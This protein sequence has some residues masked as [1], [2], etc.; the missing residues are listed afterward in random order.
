MLPLTAWL[1]AANLAQLVLGVAQSVILGRWLGV[2]VYGELGYLLSMV[3]VADAVAQAGLPNI[4]IREV[5]AR[6][7]GD[8][9]VFGTAM[10]IRLALALAAA[11]AVWPVAGPWASALVLGY[12]GSLG[13]SALRAKLLRGP[14][15]AASLLPILLSTAALALLAARMA[16]SAPLALAV[17][18]VAGLLAGAGQFAIAK[19]HLLSGL[20]WSLWQGRRLLEESWPLWLGTLVVAWM[21]R[22]DVFL[23]KA[24]P[25]PVAS[26]D[27]IGWYQAAFKPIESGHNLLGALV[28]TAFPLF[29]ARAHRPAAL[30]SA[31]D[32][33]LR[34]ARLFGGAAMLAALAGGPWAIRLLYGE[35]YAQSGPAIRLLAPAL[36]LVLTNA[37]LASLLTA[38]GRQRELLW[39]TVAMVAFKLAGNLAVIPVWSFTGSAAMTTLTEAFGFGLL[40][41]RVRVKLDTSPRL[42]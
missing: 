16:P 40:W 27:A 28:L 22:I 12:A 2:A 42:T 32:A 36:V 11:A 23:L 41:W 31:L 29:S 24:L 19:V 26:A 13:V 3:M 39:I 20:G 4:V 34:H 18:A 6:P 37:L 30:R 38:A 7:R 9:L 17:L 5:A 10:A 15:I 8:G 33:N 35:A 14:Q 1:A 25:G 21:Y